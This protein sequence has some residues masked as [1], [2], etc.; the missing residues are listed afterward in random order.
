M[1]KTGR[2]KTT[3][4]YVIQKANGALIAL[5]GPS[6]GYPYEAYSLSDVKYWNT[7]EDA[8]KYWNVFKNGAATDEGWK[9]KQASLTITSLLGT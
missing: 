3:D 2:T 6:G 5:D 1:A 9:I 8:H 7:F 4:L